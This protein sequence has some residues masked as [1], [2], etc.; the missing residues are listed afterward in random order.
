MGSPNKD[1]SLNEAANPFRPADANV[2]RQR[3]PFSTIFFPPNPH[4]IDRPKISD[5]LHTKCAQPAARVALVG[6]GGIG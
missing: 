4:F 5:W 2:P 1:A 3:K 6:P